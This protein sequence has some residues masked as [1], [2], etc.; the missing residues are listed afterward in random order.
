MS[1]NLFFSNGVK[2][3]GDNRYIVLAFAGFLDFQRKTLLK[4]ERTFYK[5]VKHQCKQIKRV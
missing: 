5:L 4:K 2:T 1:C 3:G